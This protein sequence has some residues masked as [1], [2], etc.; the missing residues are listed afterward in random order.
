MYAGYEMPARAARWVS[1]RQQRVALPTMPGETL[2]LGAAMG[3]GH[4]LRRGIAEVFNLTA[5]PVGVLRADSW[6]VTANVRS[7]TPRA[8]EELLA[9]AS[10]RLR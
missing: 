3:A 4:A 5:P 9:L 8:S 10:Q 2:A 7:W 6:S 1:K